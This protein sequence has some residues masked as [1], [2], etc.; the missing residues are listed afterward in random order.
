MNFSTKKS[1]VAKDRVFIFEKSPRRIIAISVISIMTGCY[2]IKF[3]SSQ[4][5]VIIL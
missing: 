2:T 5:K 3:I 1:S 4:K